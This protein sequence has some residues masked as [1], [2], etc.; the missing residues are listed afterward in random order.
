[1][2]NKMVKTIKFSLDGTYWVIEIGQYSNSVIYELLSAK[3]GKLTQEQ[4][5]LM[6]LMKVVLD[7]IKVKTNKE[8]IDEMTKEFKRVFRLSFWM[9][10][11]NNE[12]KTEEKK[13]IEDKC[14]ECQNELILKQSKKGTNFIGCSTWPNCYYT[15]SESLYKKIKELTPDGKLPNLDEL[16]KYKQKVN[17]YNFSNIEEN[18]KKN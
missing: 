4:K 5:Y 8:F 15:L 2:E 1:M 7:N 18:S 9:K 16:D 12:N 14:P 13:V 3:L 17:S 11:E 6:K 10:D